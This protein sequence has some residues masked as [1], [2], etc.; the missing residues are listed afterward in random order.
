MIN[1]KEISYY[2]EIT[3]FIE[4]QLQSN[5][6]AQ[7]IDNIHIYWKIGEMK[8]K[9]EEL[10]KE[11][12][13]DCNCIKSFVKR[14]PPLN[15]DIFAVI[16][17]GNIFELIILEVKFKKSVGLMQWSQLIGYCMVVDCK[18]G[19]LINVDGI[20]S[21]RLIELLNNNIN[22]S[23]IV[24]YRNNGDQTEALLGFMQWN[25]ITKNF[26]Y[27]GLGQLCSISAISNELIKKFK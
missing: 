27:S 19:L 14:M 23:K 18:F 10:I 25:S 9:I 7:N 22:V 2:P 11:H 5:F 8:S 17:N 3:K 20:A 4:M 21:T 26:E 13:N 1:N 15:V 24:R 16:T 12:P 6:R